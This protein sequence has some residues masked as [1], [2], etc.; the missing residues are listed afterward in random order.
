MTEDERAVPAMTDA[1]GLAPTERERLA[2]E[3]GAIADEVFATYSPASQLSW[4]RS[5]V[6]RWAKGML[7]IADFII[8][9]D[10]TTS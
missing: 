9:R 7:A 1:A 8:A 6:S 5:P 2:M 3:I 4:M 10:S